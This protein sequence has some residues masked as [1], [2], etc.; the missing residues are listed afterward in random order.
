MKRNLVTAVAGLVAMGGI[1]GVVGWRMGEAHGS[2]NGSTGGEGDFSG[3]LSAPLLK[4]GGDESADSKIKAAELSLGQVE[5]LRDAA[6]SLKARAQL[7]NH[8]AS[9]SVDGVRAALKAT[10]GS[11]SPNDWVFTNALMERWAELDVEGM[12]AEAEVST[13]DRMRWYGVGTAFR[14]LAEKGADA[15]WE[16]AEVLG[17][18]MKRQALSGMLE[19][20]KIDQ[21]QRALDL[22]AR[23]NSPNDWLTGS[24]MAHW[25]TKDPVAAAAAALKLPIGEHRNGALSRLAYTWAQRDSEAALAWSQGL[26]NAAERHSAVGRVL[27]QLAQENPD[28][29]RKLLAAGGEHRETLIRALT[30]SM[31]LRDFDGALA[32][33]LEQSTFADKSAALSSVTSDL[34]PA[35]A[36]RLME[37]AKSLP[38]NLAGRIYESGIWEMS[39]N[40]PERLKEW[41]KQIPQVSIRERVMKQAAESVAWRS[42]ELAVG[43]FEKL[44]PSAQTPD[45]ASRIARS[46]A[47][48]NPEGAAKWAAGM[49]NVAVRSEALSAVMQSWGNRDPEG[50]K[51]YIEK[52]DNA[53]VRRDA[54]RSLA[55]GVASRDLKAAEKWALSLDG[56]DRSAALASVVRNAS[57]RD[58]ERTPE[59]YESFVSG[60]DGDD[61][62]RSEYHAIARSVA[63]QMA[64]T[65]PG[66]AVDWLESLSEGAARDEAMGGIASAWAEYDPYAT[67]EWLHGQPAGSGRDIAAQK[68][69]GTI[70]RDDPESAWAWATAIG[71]PARRR[72]AAATVIEAWKANGL[73]D[74]AA[75]AL[76]NSGNE[77]FSASE[78]DELAKKLD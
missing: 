15:A 2:G 34:T 66:K 16:R 4:R 55:T 38:A 74:E 63:N 52:I 71:E 3:R 77:L 5:R 28:K 6:G 17:T 47:N 76:G 50:A 75:A 54:M 43:F 64:Q 45:V 31:A 53:E 62:N 51:E 18:W 22:I 26:S 27:R 78:L 1:G 67:S 44:Q 8:A 46:L 24:V 19:H 57:V 69:V 72:E 12:L 39:Y 7:I 59:L 14:H 70:A 48:S 23:S 32:F 61:A 73:R 10:K 13:D 29:A 9:L 49:E 35:E 41:I 20:M 36:E 33:A 40:D 37:V 65:E 21:P 56:A 60:L 58:P 30:S 11:N 42:P 68:L 25:A